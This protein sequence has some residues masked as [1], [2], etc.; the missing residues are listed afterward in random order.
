M[1][2]RPSIIATLLAGALAWPAPA[3]AEP[4]SGQAVRIEVDVSALPRGTRY[5]EDTRRWV[6]RNQTAV[7]EGAGFV[8]RDDASKAVRIEISRYGEHGV[9]T[10]A[11]LMVVGDAGSVREIEC[12]SCMDSKFLARVDEET[13]ALAKRLRE[14]PEV[15]AMEP[16]VEPAP[17]PEPEPEPEE[18]AT[19]ETHEEQANGDEP[20][21]HESK[22]LGAAGYAGIGA[23]AAG[24]G[25]TLG[26]IVVLTE[27]A[28]QRPRPDHDQDFEVTDR[29]PLGAGLTVVGAALLVSGAALL[30]VD[31]TVLRKRRAHRA[32]ASIVMPIVSPAALGFSWTTRF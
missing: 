16:A 32:R 9:H 10:R 26:G 1:T 29:V 28:S 7:L 22:R 30:A 15:P 24:L 20:V 13:A 21:S 4:R 17:A 14:A 31:Q 11:R 19:T 3:G 6:L 2:I 25:V 23:L 27:D 8:V 12:E 5:T 18:Q